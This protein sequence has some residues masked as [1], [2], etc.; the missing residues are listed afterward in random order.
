RHQMNLVHRVE[1]G[2]LGAIALRVADVVPLLVGGGVGEYPGGKREVERRFHLVFVDEVLDADEEFLAG[3]ALAMR[4]FLLE[5]V[6]PALV[7]DELEDELRGECTGEAGVVELVEVDLGLLV[8]D[9]REEGPLVVTEGLQALGRD[10]LAE[11]L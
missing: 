11:M 1:E 8:L 7:G 5:E 6:I 3:D 2:V 4:V 9:L 10:E